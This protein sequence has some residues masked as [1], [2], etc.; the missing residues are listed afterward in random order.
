MMKSNKR[1]MTSIGGG[2]LAVAVIAVITVSGAKKKAVALHE[3]ETKMA[4]QH[5]A[6]PVELEE[7]KLLDVAQE[8]SYPGVVQASEEFS[9]SFRVGGPLLE[10][11][12]KQGEFVSAGE[13]L[14]QI[15][16]RDFKD[17]IHALDAQLAGAVAVLKNAKS[18]YDRIRQLFD[19]KV[20]P[21]ADLDRAKGSFDVA[22]ASVKTLKAQLN[23]AQHRLSDTTLLA[24]CDG[25]VTRQLVEQY[26]MV[27]SGE[28]VVKFH[29]IQSLEVVV[30]VPGN[31]IARY[32]GTSRDIWGWVIFPASYGKKY[33]AKLK[34]WSSE[35]D[36]ITRTYA[37]TL[38]FEAPQD[39]WVLPGMS[40]KVIWADDQALARRFTVPV[41]ALVPDDAGNSCLW[42][43]DTETGKAELR[44][45]QTGPM[46]GTF[47][48]VVSDGLAPGEKVVVSGGRFIHEGMLL[49]EADTSR[50][51]DPL[52]GLL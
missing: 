10:V 27:S 21:Q 29:N 34:E 50:P 23:I 39:L 51:I 6:R 11:N 17:A 44:V 45:V 15:D 30:N 40:A 32:R 42:V 9:L 37:V 4:V 36:S 2:I 38:G 18:D 31:V 7:V 3:A 49:K 22:A 33:K 46:M 20:S 24:P 1:M 35:A 47:R 43:Y 8:W 16:P 12:I 52:K 26:E 5:S 25:I 13:V 41:S 48:I 14:M 28:V 19:E